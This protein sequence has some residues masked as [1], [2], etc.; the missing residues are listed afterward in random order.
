MD[1]SLKNLYSFSQ[2]LTQ[3]ASQTGSQIDHLSLT[4]LQGKIKKFFNYPSMKARPPSAVIFNVKSNESTE[5]RSVA[6][7]RPWW[8]WDTQLRTWAHGDEQ[9][10]TRLREASPGRLCGATPSAGRQS[11]D[12]I[13][14]ITGIFNNELFWGSLWNQSFS[15][16]T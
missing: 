15:S 5:E 11:Q 10:W 16:V 8:H 2:S 3:F 6:L 1:G 4:Y 7:A 9:D 14:A 12:S 13:V